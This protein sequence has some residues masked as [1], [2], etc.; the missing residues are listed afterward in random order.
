MN[1][2]RILIVEDNTRTSA[3]VETYLQREGFRTLAIDD[4]ELAIAAIDRYTFVFVILDLMLPSLDGWEIC[5]YLRTRSQVPILFLTARDEEADRVAGLEIGADDYVVKPFSPR[6]LV[7]RVKAILRRSENMLQPRSKVLTMG[8]LTLSEEKRR[9]MID[10][11]NVSVTGSEFTLLHT[12]MAKPGRV[13]SREELLDRLYP[14]GEP[15]VDRVVDVHI[16]K[17]RRKIE[18]DSSQPSLIR[19]V[20]GIGYQLADDIIH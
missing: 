17:L 6:E 2:R 10:G 8:S 9:V 7:A 3:L 4:G 1:E 20:R 11:R 16:G 5:R 15:V 14:N 12:L 18:C 13:F 19:T